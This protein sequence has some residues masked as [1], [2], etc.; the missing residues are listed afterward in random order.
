MGRSMVVEQASEVGRRVV[1]EG[2]VS[3]EKDFELDLLW[4]RE[5]VEVLEDWGYVGMGLGEQASNGVL[6]VLE[7][8]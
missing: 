7:F 8:I 3:E 2:F 5:L 6:D 4:G 1:M